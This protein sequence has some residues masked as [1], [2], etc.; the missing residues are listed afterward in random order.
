[1]HRGFVSPGA[2]LA[3]ASALVALGTLAGCSIFRPEPEP[4]PVEPAKP[5]LAVKRTSAR[6]SIGRRHFS[7]ACKMRSTL[8]IASA[9]VYVAL[10]RSSSP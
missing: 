5:K 2:G 4:V 9:R 6:P 10:R 3:R 1:M 8:T 7:I